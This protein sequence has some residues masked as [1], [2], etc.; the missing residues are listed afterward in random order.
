[1]SRVNLLNIAIWGVLAVCIVL[2]FS[3][4]YFQWSRLDRTQRS[5]VVVDRNIA[6]ADAHKRTL[7]SKRREPTWILTQPNSEHEDSD[8][9]NQL[10]RLIRIAGVKQVQI[11]RTNL[12]PLP[13]YGK[14]S[15]S[16]GT[17]TS[18]GSQEP[19]KAEFSLVNLPLGAQ[20]IATNL[21]VQ[22]SYMNVRAFL[23]QIRN[24][25]YAVRAINLN[26]VMLS[27][28]DSGMVRA[29][30][31]ITRF[32]VPRG[33]INVQ[34]TPASAGR[35]ASATDSDT[36]STEVSPAARQPGSGTMAPLN[37]NTYARPGGPLAPRPA[38]GQ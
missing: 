24:F 36:S 4:G 22:G 18:S 10:Q 8:F 23:Y 9:L 34:E 13:T 6:A 38:G 15:A 31:S 26:N 30:M 3:Y 32:V 14:P 29:T 33:S 28:D 35:P 37:P 5:R 12:S 16:S 27:A 25:R 11:D 17:Q 1:M 20:A 7:D 19:G 21:V 2:A